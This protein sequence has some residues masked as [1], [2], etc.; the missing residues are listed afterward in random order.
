LT[1][2]SLAVCVVDTRNY[3]LACE[4]INQT[5]RVLASCHPVSRV[6][7]ISDQL[8]DVSFGLP[9][10]N[11]QISPIEKF[12]LDYNRVCLSLIPKL[13]K[14]DFCLMVQTDGYAC[15]ASAWTASFFDYDYI[16]AVFSPVWV[17]NRD[18]S[19][20][21]GGFS[22]R[23]RRLFLALDNLS[24]EPSYNNEDTEI[25]SRYRDVLTDRYHIKFAPESIA[26]QFSVE[27]CT[28]T[29]WLGRS[30]GFH[31]SH[32]IRNH[33]FDISKNTQQNC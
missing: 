2:P 23:S 3:Q 19:V 10:E 11:I 26:E 22:L 29:S 1:Q 33:Y 7:W 28:N 18:H 13:V 30:F 5:L 32:D 31:G 15:N 16:G 20:G 21:N 24:I 6:Y 27:Y 8:C 17:P 9:T 12:P 25:C 14:E 4:A